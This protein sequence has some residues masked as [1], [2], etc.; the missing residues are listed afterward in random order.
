MVNEKSLA[1]HSPIDGVIQW[2][3]PWPG[4]SNADASASEPLQ[5]DDRRLLISKGYGEG[6]M[7]VELTPGG[8][9]KLQARKLWSQKS[10]LR[11][12]FTNAVLFEGH[13]YAL[14]D[15]ILECVELEQGKRKWKKGR[16]GHGQLLR[17]G[18]HLLIASEEGELVLVDA[19]PDQF[20]E[21]AKLPVI[22]AP[23]GTFQPSAMTWLSFGTVK[24]W[25]V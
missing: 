19:R 14:S 3:L 23:L 18:R 11:T 1:G 6:A 7:M 22:T 20:Q 12:K 4:S 8:D 9:G 10:Q 24:R 13:A 17:V 15:G 25:R 2:E 16:Y 5:V 21:L